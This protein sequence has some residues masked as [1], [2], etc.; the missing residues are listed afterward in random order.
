MDKT[1]YEMDL[2]RMIE[3]IIDNSYFGDFDDA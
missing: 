1:D 2:I 3:M